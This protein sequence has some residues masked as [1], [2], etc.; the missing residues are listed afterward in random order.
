[1]NFSKRIFSNDLF[2]MDFSNEL[3]QKIFPNE[4]F[5]NKFLQMAAGQHS[6]LLKKTT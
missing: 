6:A 2:Q 3:F 5:A 4:L 1:M